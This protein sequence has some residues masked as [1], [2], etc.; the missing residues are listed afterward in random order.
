MWYRYDHLSFW[1][2]S[3]IFQFLTRVPRVHQSNPNSACFGDTKTAKEL[4]VNH[5]P[6]IIAFGSHAKTAKSCENVTKH[7][8]HQ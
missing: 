3:W 4:R 1:W 7:G 8:F 5:T 6:T 2:P